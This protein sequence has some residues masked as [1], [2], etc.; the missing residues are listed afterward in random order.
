MREGEI[1][2][3]IVVGRLEGWRNSENDRGRKR[4]GREK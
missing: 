3:R 2:R 4:V 1:E